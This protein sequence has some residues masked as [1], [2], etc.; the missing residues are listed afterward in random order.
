MLR[1]IVWRDLML[2]WRRR[3]DMLSTVFFFVIVVSL[4]PLGIG[5]NRLLRRDAQISQS[6]QRRL[7]DFFGTPD[8]KNAFYETKAEPR[9]FGVEAETIKTTDFAGIG[10]YFVKR[11][12][13]IFAGVAK[14]PLAL[15]NSAN[16]PL[17]LLCFAAGNERGAKTAVKIAQSILKP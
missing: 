17:Y 5:V 2:A 6:W 4:F 14:N 1:W 11:L 7:D 15:H 13:T 9:L 12:E 3:A 16:T 10:R 8:W